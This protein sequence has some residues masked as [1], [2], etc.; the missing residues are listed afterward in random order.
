MIEE[1]K[2]ANEKSA[3]DG[4][5]TEDLNENSVTRK[6]GHTDMGD[7]SDMLE[8]GTDLY[9]SIDAK[10][11]YTSRAYIDE[12]PSMIAIRRIDHG[13]SFDDRVQ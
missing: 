5:V 12:H 10:G 11:E 4:V 1:A 6:L 3:A 7:I 13:E 9:K 2:I 8:R